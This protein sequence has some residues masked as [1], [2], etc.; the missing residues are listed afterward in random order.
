MIVSLAG[1]AEAQYGSDTPLGISAS[2]NADGSVSGEIAGGTAPYS[3]TATVTANGQ[4]SSAAVTVNADGTYSVAAGTVPNGA[5]ILIRVTDADGA[6]ATITAGNGVTTTTA[7][8]YTGPFSAAPAQ[9]AVEF[10]TPLAAKSPAAAAGT[11]GD[12]KLAFT[13]AQSSMLVVGGMS[14]VLVGGVAVLA[15]RKRPE[16]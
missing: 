5:R 10:R 3:A 2:V 1:V 4:V 7:I 9:V 13:G 6:R 15:A 11:G 14:L 16:F 8:A 12:A